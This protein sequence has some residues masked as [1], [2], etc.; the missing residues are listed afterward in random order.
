MRHIG[1]TLLL[2]LVCGG[3]AALA[4]L[5]V[6]SPHSS[7]LPFSSAPPDGYLSFTQTSVVFLK[8]TED[9]QHHLQGQ[10]MNANITDDPTKLSYKTIAFTGVHNGQDITLTF[11]LGALPFNAPGTLVGDT[12][13]LQMQGKDGKIETGTYHAATIQ[14]FNDAL[15]AL[16]KHIKH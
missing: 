15:V 16:E 14:Q 2:M 4:T 9:D 11:S 6:L 10:L 8:W 12:L 7:V 3:I 5:F 1:I 13:T